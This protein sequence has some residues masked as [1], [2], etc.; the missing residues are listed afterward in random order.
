MKFELNINKQTPKAEE[1]VLM[2]STI[3][4]IEEFMAFSLVQKNCAGLAAN[5]CLIDGILNNKKYFVLIDL[6]HNAFAYINPVIVTKSKE[7]K[8]FVEGCL[9]WPDKK[10]KAWRSDSISVKY[11]DLKGEMKEEQLKDFHAQVFQHEYNHLMGI[12]EE[13]LESGNLVS[14]K[15][16]RNDPCYCGSGEKYKKCCGK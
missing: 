4:E 1:I 6:H 16:G 11:M 10:I 8:L 7:Q 5:Q 13:I 12:E 2:E 15:I 14:E 3:K 9:S